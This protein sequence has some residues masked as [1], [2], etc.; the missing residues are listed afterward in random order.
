MQTMCR[1][2]Y[3]HLKYDL[4]YCICAA[5]MTYCVSKLALMPSVARCCMMMMDRVRRRSIS[6]RVDAPCCAYVY[7]VSKCIYRICND[8]NDR[9]DGLHNWINYIVAEEDATCGK[10]WDVPLMD[11][12][13]S[14]KMTGYTEMHE[15]TYNTARRDVY[16]MDAQSKSLIIGCFL[17]DAIK[18]C[19]IWRNARIFDAQIYMLNYIDIFS[20]QM[21]QQQWRFSSLLFAALY[22]SFPIFQDSLPAI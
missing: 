20:G 15:N 11:F 10:R 14:C 3:T 17:K 16:C 4:R 12:E 1:V 18:I 21:N 2:I 5:L 8:E 6:L 19:D 13:K 7:S 9:R 22:H